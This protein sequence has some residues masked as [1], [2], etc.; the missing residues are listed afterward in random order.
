MGELLPSPLEGD[1]PRWFCPEISTFVGLYSDNF[2]MAI[3]SFHDN[4][5]PYIP[6]LL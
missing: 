6:R 3:V 1:Q 5:A 2:N 4:Q